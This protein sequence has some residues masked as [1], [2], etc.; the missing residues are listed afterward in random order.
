MCNFH[1]LLQNGTFLTP[2]NARQKEYSVFK[3]NGEI[4][5]HTGTQLD[6]HEGNY[7][8]LSGNVI[9]LISDICDS[10]SWLRGKGWIN[11]GSKTTTPERGTFEEY[12]LSLRLQRGQSKLGRLGSFMSPLLAADGL[13]VADIEGGRPNKI[14]LKQGI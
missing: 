11:I 7:D 13:N 8:T 3:R 12:L 9:F 10:I 2:D 6:M 14:R 1:D 4:H 5:C